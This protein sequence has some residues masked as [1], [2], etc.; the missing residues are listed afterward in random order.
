VLAL[1]LEC[2]AIEVPVLV[3]VWELG[4]LCDHNVADL[5]GGCLYQRQEYMEQQF[6]LFGITQNGA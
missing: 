1:T 5:A 6:L 2:G 4:Q 3:L